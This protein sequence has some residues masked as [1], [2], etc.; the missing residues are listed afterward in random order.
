[1]T[2]AGRGVRAFAGPGRYLQGPGALDRLGEVLAG[3]PRTPFV[4]T[5]QYVRQLL[6]QRLGSTLTDAGLLPV[7]GELPGEITYAAVAALCDAGRDA[8]VVVGV[9]GGKTL[10]AAKA[11]ALKLDLPVVTV[12]TI[13]S[14]D[15][16]ASGAIAMHDER[17]VMVSVDRLPRH[18]ELVLVDT[19]LIAAAPVEFLRAGIGDAIS[20]KFEAEACRAGTGTV[21][22]GGRPLLVGA[23]IAD[24]CYR[25]IRTH[26]VGALQAC[27]DNKVTSDLEAV[28]EAVILMS[29]LAFENGGLSLAHALTRGLAVAR[30]AASAS[31]GRHVAWGLLVQLAAERRA[32]EDIRELADFLRLVGLPSS[33]ADLGLPDPNVAEITAIA[34]DAMTAPHVCNMPKPITVG[35]IT[36]AVERVERIARKP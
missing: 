33:L 31:H 2:G 4:V 22:V 34:E 15:S 28:V 5:D 24:A 1:M 18:P 8:G 30:G 10:D 35:D 29:G 23:A 12:P 20:K 19:H 14:N 16:P 27:A 36:A 9:G 6:G 25:T 11:V 21:P 17:H 3:Y 32:A 13:A 7:F 26:A